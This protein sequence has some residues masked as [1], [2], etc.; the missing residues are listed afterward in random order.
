MNRRNLLRTLLAGA[1][2]SPLSSIAGLAPQVTVYKSAGCGCCKEWIKHLETNGFAVKAVDVESPSDYR[3]RAGI[4]SSLGACHTGMSGGYGFEGHVPAAD[5][6][7][8]LAE[9]PKARG[10]AVPAMPVGSPGMEG[11]RKDPFD[12]FL[13]KLD[14][15]RSTYR[16][17]N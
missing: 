12:V 7:R 14:G 15:S 13:V 5:I 1:V 10:L 17:Y 16:H 8:F 6:K 4:P 3:S 2:F 9:R 11:P